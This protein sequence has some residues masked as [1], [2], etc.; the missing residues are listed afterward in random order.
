MTPQFKSNSASDFSMLKRSHEVLALSE[1][2]EVLNK[3]RKKP[4][5]KIAKIFNTLL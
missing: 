1:K 4:Y 3:E 2:V 5:A